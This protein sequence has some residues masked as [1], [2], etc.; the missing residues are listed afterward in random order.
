MNE[1]EDNVAAAAARPIFRTKSPDKNGLDGNVS[2]EPGNHVVSLR[3]LHVNLAF[4]DG[5]N[6]INRLVA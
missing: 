1:D 4:R 3:G 6:S 5:R 2:R